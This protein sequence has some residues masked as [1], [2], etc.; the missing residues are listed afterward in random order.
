MLLL[1]YFLAFVA[2]VVGTIGGF[3]SSIF[4]IPIAS[5]YFEPKLVLG[6]TAFF[7][8]F[9]NISKLILFGK[10]I[11]YKIAI[12][13]IIPSVIGVIIGALLIV[14]QPNELF[15]LIIGI[16]LILFSIY[17][18]IYPKQS[19]DATNKNIIIGGTSAGFLA[20]FLGTGGV[21]RGA[22]MAAFNLE[23]NAFVATSALVDLFVDVSRSF[24]YYK[25]E[26]IAFDKLFYILPLII[27]S[28][29]GSYVGK[30]ILE[31]LNQEKFRKIVLILISMMGALSVIRFLWQ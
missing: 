31:R 12:K 30:I 21:I 10:K 28:F 29:I 2:E 13:F 18:L 20:G 4:F 23:K 26:F 16:F 14:N 5:F 24:I 1:F 25:N 9:S 8:V 7:H 15:A 11:E 19:I 17:F 27:I 3:G 6:I 22:A